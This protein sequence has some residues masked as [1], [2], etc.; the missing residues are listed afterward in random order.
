MRETDHILN[1]VRIERGLNDT[2]GRVALWNTVVITKTQSLTHSGMNKHRL[3]EQ[4]KH[5]TCADIWY[6]TKESLKVMKKD[7]LIN[8]AGISGYT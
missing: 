7:I 3:R 6:I 1:V 8:S 4:I 5:N 2:M